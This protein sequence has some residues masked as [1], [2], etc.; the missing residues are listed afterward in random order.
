M[1][2][3]ATVTT[4]WQYFPA[5]V[6]EV[7]I[8]SSWQGHR[9]FVYDYIRNV[10]PALVVE[11]GTHTG[12]SLFAMCQAVKDGGL[13]TRI[14]AVDTWRGDAFTKDYDDI[15]K[16]RVEASLRQHYPGV[17]VTLVQATFNDALKEWHEPIDLLHIDGS[18]R[19]ADAR[20]DWDGWSPH[21]RPE[22]LTMIHDIAVTDPRFGVWR[23]WDELEAKY[24][25]GAMGFNHSF[26]LGLIRKEG[27]L[28]MA[29]KWYRKYRGID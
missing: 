13:P 14:V 20:E 18:H 7:D 25:E 3:T 28:E 6:W 15:V 23:L 5:P 9:R 10:R 2:A 4:G 21:V 1:G 11:L 29:D 19:Y 12:C 8:T 24:Q 26:G 22:G 27:R 16:E 17:N